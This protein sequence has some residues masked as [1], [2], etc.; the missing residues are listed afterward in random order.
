MKPEPFGTVLM[1]LVIRQRRVNKRA[2][3]GKELVTNILHYKT[4]DGVVVT[5]I[6]TTL[7]NMEKKIALAIIQSIEENGLLLKISIEANSKV[8]N[9][10]AEAVRETSQETETYGSSGSN[11]LSGLRAESKSIAISLDQTL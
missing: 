9:L 10:I 4:M 1:Q 7:R 11:T 2:M 3:I 8:V 6:G 5:I